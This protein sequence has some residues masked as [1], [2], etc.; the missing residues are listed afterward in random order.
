MS[1]ASGWAA[2]NLEMTDMV[3]RTE[4]SA[5]AHWPLVR[6][7]TGIPV[8]ADSPSEM[9][10]KA[11]A[12]FLKEWDY[13]FFWNTLTGGNIFGEKKTRMGHAVYADGGTDYDAE[14]KELFHDPEEVYRYDMYKEYGTPDPDQLTKEYND[15]YRRMQAFQP[16]CVQMTGIYVTCMSGLIELMGWEMLLYAAGEDPKAF[17]DFVNRYCRWI[18]QYFEALSR[19]DSPVVMIHDDI[20]WGNGPFM[21]P[22]FYRK[23]VFANYKKM[24]RPLIEAGKKILFTSDGNYTQFV[25][26]IAACGVHGFVMEPVTDLK[27]IVERYGKTHVIVGNA[28]TSILLLGSRDD[29]EREVRRCMDTAR[30]CPG[31]IM[32]VGNHIPANTPVENA[33]YYDE[34]YRKYAKR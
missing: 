15:N 22:D 4:Y 7:V 34:M 6:A 12:Q 33:L 26:D 25:D 27:Y 21:S 23:Y 28:D 9:Q 32:A 11:S 13:A 2:M 16:D 5:H 18:S 8:Q 20:V 1:Y 17:G 10:E 19:C 14:R 31:F 3:P 24:F 30:Q 29:I